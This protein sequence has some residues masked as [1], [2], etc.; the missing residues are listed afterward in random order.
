MNV[1]FATEFAR[2]AKTE[3][4]DLIWRKNLLTGDSGKTKVS[5]SK[6]AIFDVFL[7]RSRIHL[8]MITYTILRNM[9]DS[10]KKAIQIAAPLLAGE[11]DA[12]GNAARVGRARKWATLDGTAIHRM[13]VNAKKLRRFVHLHKRD[14]P[15]QAFGAGCKTEKS[16]KAAFAN[17]MEND[18]N[19][20]IKNR[21]N[22]QISS[23]SHKNSSAFSNK[24]AETTV[25]QITN[26]TEKDSKCQ[27]KNRFSSQILSRSHDY[28]STPL[29]QDATQKS[30]PL[31][32]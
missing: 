3:Y 7:L 13:G 16:G 14:T 18:S 2:K 4:H 8:V 28:W 24:L 11:I 6:P 19:R 21:F 20:Q 1:Q 17:K 30:Q 10:F 32:E 26:R 23:R 29:L 25:A 12:I 31:R 15:P 27:I 5:K 22:A 9:P